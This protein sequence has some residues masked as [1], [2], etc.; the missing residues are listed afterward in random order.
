MEPPS[1]S[2]HL[3]YD[4]RPSKNNGTAATE[5]AHNVSEKALLVDPF[6]NN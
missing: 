4:K 6:V 5:Y 1:S 3:R 2:L